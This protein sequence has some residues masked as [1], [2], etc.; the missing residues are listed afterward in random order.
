MAH[1]S[2]KVFITE[3]GQ[4]VC[5]PTHTCTQFGQLICIPKWSFSYMAKKEVYGFWLQAGTH[6]S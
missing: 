5:V 2:M 6:T 3:T 1:I 4:V